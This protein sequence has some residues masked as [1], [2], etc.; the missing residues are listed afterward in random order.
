MATVG[1]RLAFGRAACGTRSNRRLPA[2]SI[3]ANRAI[4]KAARAAFCRQGVTTRGV[5]FCA[6]T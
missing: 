1:G 3:S 5:S 4:V 6:S 2:T